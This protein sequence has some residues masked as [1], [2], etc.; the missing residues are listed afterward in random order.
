MHSSAITPAA[1]L[2]TEG[3]VLERDRRVFARLPDLSLSPGR[4]VALTGESGAGKTTALLALAGIRAPAE[5]RILVGDDDLWSLSAS[6]RDRLRGR[7]IGLVFQSFHLIDAVSVE[8]NQ[9]LAASCAGMG[10]DSAH[11]DHLLE[12]L[13]I[14]AIRR[15]RADRLSQG[16]AQRVAVARALVNHPALVLADEPTSSLD[17]GNARA[18]LDL[19]ARAVRDHGA[20]L[21]MATHDRRVLDAVDEAVA[22]E[23]VQ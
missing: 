20:A 15:K 7:R 17:D 6:R 21:L 5:G 23:V 9:R 1:C 13:G 8:E 22:M 12:T 18:L 3:V 2:R 4:T 16:Q 10:A 11:L 14:S 19:L